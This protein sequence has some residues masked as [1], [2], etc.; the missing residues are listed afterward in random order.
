[1]TSSLPPAP[2]LLLAAQILPLLSLIYSLAVHAFLSN[3]HERS[4][5]KSH[6]WIPILTRA[7]FWCASVVISI[8]YSSAY[9]DDDDYA[10]ITLLNT[11]LSGVII[12]V[13]IKF[14][15]NTRQVEINGPLPPNYY[16][17]AG[18]S[19]LQNKIILITG[20]NSGIGLETT[21]ILYHKYN[22][23]VILACRSRSRA[24]DAIRSIDPTWQSTSY[25]SSSGSIAGKRMYFI[26][27]D[28]SSFQSIRD[29]VKI[30][31]EMDLPLHVLV[32]NAGVM[33][34]DRLESVDGFEM[35]MAAN[36]STKNLFFAQVVLTMVA[37][38]HYHVFVSIL[39]LL[40]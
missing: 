7:S 21:R 1:M 9:V 35:T 16:N 30:F 17:N 3:F 8:F 27:M 28:L 29:G 33:M 34:N 11:I 22:A 26:P 31:L 19:S 15:V 12:A 2:L 24:V 38:I 32:N 37:F 14:I 5:L 18:L 25:N 6:H 39:H 36:V 4:F 40:L 23:T 13:S 10:S 20:A